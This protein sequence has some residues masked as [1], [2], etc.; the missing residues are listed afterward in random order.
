MLE[1]SFKGLVLPHVSGFEAG[2]SL[3]CCKLPAFAPFRAFA[4]FVADFVSAFLWPR[5]RPTAPPKATPPSPPAGQRMPPHTE[6]L[7][8]DPLPLAALRDARLD[9]LYTGRFTHFNPIQ[10]QA[11]AGRRPG[12]RFG[13]LGFSVQRPRLLTLACTHPGF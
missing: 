4:F 1:L 9:G 11:R 5:L 8:L 10:T 2:W 6:L 12:P 13:T 3:G 7:D